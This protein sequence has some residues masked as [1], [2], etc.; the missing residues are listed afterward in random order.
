MNI[1]FVGLG[2]LGL[3]VCIG[4]ER[5]GHTVIGY[6]INPNI[7]SKTRP[8][9][10]LYT[11]EVWEDGITPLRNIAIQTTNLRFANSLEEV[12][13]KS[14]IIF[15]A[16]Q[17]PHDA[18]Y[19]GVTP[20]TKSRKDFDY[21]YLIQSLSGISEIVEKIAKNTIVIVISTVLPGT[22][23]RE[24]LPILSPY[25]KFCYNPYFIAMGS[26][27]PDLY[28]PEFILFGSVCEDTT[29][30]VVKFYET[31]TSAPVYTTTLENA[32][33]IKVSYNTF[34][35]AKICIAN[36]IM[37]MCDNLPGTNCEEIMNG[38]F[39]AN[40]RLISK[41]YLHGGMGDGGGCHPRDNIA[42]SW[43]STSIGLKY[44]FYEGLM[45]TRE[46]Q[47]EYFAEKLCNLQ[48]NTI[49]KLPIILLGKSFKPDTNIVTGSPAILLANY[50]KS[51]GCSF[52]HEDHI[53]D[54]NELSLTKKAMYFISTKHSS[55]EHAY[56]PNG[57]IVVD[58]FRYIKKTSNITYIPIG[59]SS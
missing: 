5:K 2:K 21:S 59:I 18:L 38:L 25:V 50:M 45:K 42:L 56:F 41:N 47:T 57:S 8:E 16:V 22:I 44:D 32:E 43:L 26:V 19:E 27:I 12:I 10:I 49:E 7:T 30:T 40:K 23:R 31:I 17:T 1:G 15:V 13:E 53:I 14:D 9:D 46:W 39:M 3:P 24:I 29:N 35:T 36:Q 6:D 34:I 52:D 37:I 51:R 4:F 20:I 33:M 54:C 11:N 48:A 55:Y 58:P 28:N